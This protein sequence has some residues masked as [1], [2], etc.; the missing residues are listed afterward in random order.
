MNQRKT[1]LGK[2]VADRGLTITDAAIA[3]GVN[4]SQFSLYVRGQKPSGS[5]AEKIA[6]GMGSSVKEL[7]PELEAK[8]GKDGA[9]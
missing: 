3:C 2:L 8:S 1:N 9:K 6:V 7:W 4:V 5:T